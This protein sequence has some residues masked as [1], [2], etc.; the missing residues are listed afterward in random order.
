MSLA[1][2]LWRKCLR[3]G[4]W[5]TE[6]ERDQKGGW[7]RGWRNLRD[8]TLRKIYCKSYIELVISFPCQIHRVIWSSDYLPFGSCSTDFPQS[9][10]VSD[11][12][13]KVWGKQSRIR[14]RSASIRHLQREKKNVSHQR[15]W[16]I[17][18]VHAA[19]QITDRVLDISGS[20]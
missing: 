14:K 10:T 11:H 6:R 12:R 13:R 1:D 5:K 3:K 20:H 17:E 15:W 2:S 8:V 7:R 19:H 9:L 4:R 16:L 18:E